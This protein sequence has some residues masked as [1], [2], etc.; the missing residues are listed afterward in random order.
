M[1]KIKTQPWRQN[2]SESINKKIE[3]KSIFRE[4][5]SWVI[6]IIAFIILL[7]GFIDYRIDQ[8]VNNP[9]FVYQVAKKV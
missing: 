5:I 7:I 2:M 6:G 8:K 9:D 1:V 4:N 3:A